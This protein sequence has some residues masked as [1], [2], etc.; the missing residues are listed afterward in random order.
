[1]AVTEGTQC[2][3]P[4]PVISNNQTEISDEIRRYAMYLAR[5]SLR[6]NYFL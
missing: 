2:A 3:L 5:R 6:P 4:Q 1:M